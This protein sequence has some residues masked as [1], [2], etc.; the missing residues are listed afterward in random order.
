M[1]SS[2]VALI[3]YLVF[4]PKRRIP[5]QCLPGSDAASFIKPLIVSKPAYS[6]QLTLGLSVLIEAGTVIKWNQN[7][8]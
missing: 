1:L 2:A 7:L 6:S 5:L 4:T 8:R 3:L